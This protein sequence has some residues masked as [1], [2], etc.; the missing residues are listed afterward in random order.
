MHIDGL[1]QEQVKL[2]DKMWTLETIEELMSWMK[3][4]N[5]RQFHQ[6][7]VLRELLVLSL[8]DEEVEAQENFPEA[9]RMLA[10]LGY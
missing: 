8:I 10:R 7:K 4:L 2:L 5:D 9:S 3:T 1:T 6:V